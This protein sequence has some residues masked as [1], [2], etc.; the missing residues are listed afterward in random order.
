LT[1]GIVN[2]DEELRIVLGAVLSGDAQQ[3]WCG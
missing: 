3:D 2:D 1:V